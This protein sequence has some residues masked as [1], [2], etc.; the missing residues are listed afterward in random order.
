M[1]EKEGGAAGLAA[2][3]IVAPLPYS[4]KLGKH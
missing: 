2:C 3:V 1:V 4:R